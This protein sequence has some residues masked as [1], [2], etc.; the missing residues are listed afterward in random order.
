MVTWKQL[1]NLTYIH[2]HNSKSLSRC[3][4]TYMEDIP[5]SVCNNNQE[6]LLIPRLPLCITDTDQYCILD[7]IMHWNQIYFE[8]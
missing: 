5:I 1:K 6:I 2:S 8:R 7:G 3:V 4:F